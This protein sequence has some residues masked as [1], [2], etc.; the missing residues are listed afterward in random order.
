MAERKGLFKVDAVG[1]LMMW[2]PRHE[3]YLYFE[4][5][6]I[7]EKRFAEKRFPRLRHLL[8]K[9]KAKLPS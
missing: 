3:R 2:S 8:R 5:W 1:R 4:E 7:Y 9:V 6:Y